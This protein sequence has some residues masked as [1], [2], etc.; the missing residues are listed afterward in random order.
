MTRRLFVLRLGGQSLRLRVDGDDLL[1]G[2][3]D[4][5]PLRARSFPGRPDLTLAWTSGRGTLRRNGRTVHVSRTRED[6]VLWTEWLSTME[7]LRRLRSTTTLIHA[8]WMAKGRRGVLVAGPHGAGKTSLGA[9]LA[10]RR[11]W[12]LYGDD[13]TIVSRTGTLRALERP[14][15]IKPGSSPGL[16]ELPS[17][18]VTTLI[19]PRRFSRPAAARL[20][21]ILL[22]GSKP[23]A[24]RLERVDP[25]IAVATLARFTLNF[26]EAP[27]SALKTLATLTA[28][29]PT[30]TMSGGSIGERCA[31]LDRLS[32]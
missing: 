4:V 6:L 3:L 16:P 32:F 1:L 30:W 21:A 10:L 13:V 25:G 29:T 20:S 14:L 12:T 28:K 7:A 15:R 11:G 17:G 27:G 19:S 31:A 23:G 24:L 9:A 26:R 5:L 18:R 8:G 22:L 2:S